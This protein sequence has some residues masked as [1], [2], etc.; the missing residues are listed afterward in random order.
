MEVGVVGVLTVLATSVVE[1]APKQN[2]E[3][4]TTPPPEK[5]VECVRVHALF[6]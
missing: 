2:K 3:F 4:V 6:L 1:G 5:G